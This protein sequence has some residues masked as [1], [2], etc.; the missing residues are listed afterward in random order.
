MTMEM[1]INTTM[2]HRMMNTAWKS[3]I[4]FTMLPFR[5]SK[6]MVEEEVITKADRVDMEA[7]RTR[8]TTMA[9]SSSGRL[10]SMVGTMASYPSVATSTWSE[11]SRPKP[12]MK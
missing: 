12:P 7:E 4:F 3:F 1:M 8:I 5:R 9:M 10:D 2:K 6:V 11:K